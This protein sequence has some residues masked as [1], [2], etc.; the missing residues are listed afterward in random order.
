MWL[1]LRQICLVA[2]NLAP[3]EEELIDVL[4]IEKCVS[5]LGVGVFGLANGLFPFG[6]QLLE[7]VSP[8]KEDTAAGRYL[9]RRGGNG[10][11]MVI[12]QCDDEAPRRARIEE[13]GIRQVGNYETDEFKNLQMHPK[14]TGGSFFE[15]NEQVGP[16]AHELDGAWEPAGP[17][18]QRARRL[19]R[20]TGIAAAEVQCDDPQK[21]AERWA[22]IAQ[23][24][25]QQVDGVATMPLDN[26]AVRFVPCRDGR[27]EGL[28][29]IDIATAD[30]DAIL[31]AAATRGAVSGDA[32]VALGGIR[33]N[34]I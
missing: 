17:N 1:R 16:D 14:D 9:E 26:A 28:G 22:E 30:R 15:I 29:A 32:Q 34:L 25:L 10:G 31:K 4:G 33:I 7:V 13:L 18:W 5:D 21:V 27:P 20:V 12:T 3:V 11:Y 24:P 8:I 23:I 2:E 6:N 19:E